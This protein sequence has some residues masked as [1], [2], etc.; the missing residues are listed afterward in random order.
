MRAPVDPVAQEN[1]D[2]VRGYVG[3]REPV[4]R[5]VGRPRRESFARDGGDGGRVQARRCVRVCAPDE[6]AGPVVQGMTPM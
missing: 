3:E 4:A 1:L 5:A 6:G 2:D